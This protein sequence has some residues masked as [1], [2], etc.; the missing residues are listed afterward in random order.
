[1]KMGRRLR[2]RVGGSA[3]WRIGVCGRVLFRHDYND[4]EVSTVLMMLCD[5]R[6]TDTFP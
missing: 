3:H 6:H 2:K 5:R 1:M 4:Q